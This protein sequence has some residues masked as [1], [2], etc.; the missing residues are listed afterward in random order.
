[1]NLTFFPMHIV[2][3][4]GMPRR[5]YTYS[6][7]MGWTAPNMIE[8]IG[9]YLLAV[10]LLMV[11]VN[12]AVALFRGERVGNDPFGGPTLE[13]AT[14]SPP[15]PYNFPVIPT[16]S[17]PYAMWDEEDRQEDARNLERGRRV[18]E[19]GHQT[20]ASSAVDAE[21]DEVLDMPSDSI[22][23]P[24]LALALSGVFAFLLL[25]L[26]IVAAVFLG[27]CLC[28]LGFWHGKEPQEAS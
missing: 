27:F 4:L 19:R 8:T 10:G 11:M 1:M 12:L 20:A 6:G 23:P 25:K 18:L 13:W 14:T 3:V 26:W 17:S 28:V 7:G 16:V 9:S 5:D 21:W 2:G 22:L 15:P 24:V